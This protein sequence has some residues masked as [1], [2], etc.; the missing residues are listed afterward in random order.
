M[1][2]FGIFI[3]RLIVAI[4][5]DLAV[6]ITVGMVGGTRGVVVVVVVVVLVAAAAAVAAAVAVVVVVSL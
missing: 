1:L 6:V 4:S 3:Y 5:S 2:L